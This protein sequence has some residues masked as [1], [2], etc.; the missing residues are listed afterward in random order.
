[1]QGM[2]QVWPLHKPLFSENPA[3]QANY[4]H[5]KPAAHQLK[6]GTIHMHDSSEG[7]DSSDDSFR[8]QLKVQC[9]QAHNKMTQN[10][11]A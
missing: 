9:V 8:L 4:K 11:H 10:L 1:M 3:K 6:A 7:V 2:P 5:R